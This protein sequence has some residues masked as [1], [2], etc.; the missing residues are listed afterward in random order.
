MFVRARGAVVQLTR[1]SKRCRVSLTS[2]LLFLGYV[3]VAGTAICVWR[4]KARIQDIG[5][6]VVAL[7]A[8]S[9]AGSNAASPTWPSL[10]FVFGPSDCPGALDLI[11]AWDRLDAA[12]HVRV[13][14]IMVGT[15]E[16]IPDW[17]DIVRTNRITFRVRLEPRAPIL[18]RLALLGVRTLPAVLLFGERGNLLLAL[19]A[20]E[21][22]KDQEAVSE[23]LRVLPKGDNE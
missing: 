14:G 5:Q 23:V 20:S 21:I 22:D 12:G 17:L 2:A 13:Q 7:E 15:H 16:E 4:L 6:P 19:P 1:W 10:F 3:T 8:G 11:D 9:T 18:S